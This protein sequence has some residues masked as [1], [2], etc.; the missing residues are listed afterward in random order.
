MIGKAVYLSPAEQWKQYIPQGEIYMGVHSSKCQH[1][2]DRSILSLITLSVQLDLAGKRGGKKVIV[3]EEEYM[4][5][6]DEQSPL[7]GKS[8]CVVLF[9]EG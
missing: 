7:D 3:V 4:K 8:E 9:Q 5:R 1:H 2:S 6:R